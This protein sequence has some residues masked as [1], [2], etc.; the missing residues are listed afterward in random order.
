MV[1]PSD[2]HEKYGWG[3]VRL[4][5]LLAA[6]CSLPV[7]KTTAALLGAFP[8]QRVLT[9]LCFGAYGALVNSHVMRGAAL[10]G[11]SLSL[12]G[13]GVAT[14]LF[15]WDA[16]SDA[17]TPFLYIV[18]TAVGD[19]F[20]GKVDQWIWRLGCGLVA[21]GVV[22]AWA[23]GQFQLLEQWDT[24]APW[25]ALF[26]WM[27]SIQFVSEYGDNYLEHWAFFRHRYCFEVGTLALLMLHNPP[28]QQRVVVLADLVAILAYRGV[29]FI[30]VWLAG[31]HAAKWGPDA[32]KNA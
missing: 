5:L 18:K 23:L 2:R 21:L 17:L 30:I 13:L 32:E 25:A 28:T 16:K 4:L 6:V 19:F 10:G 12:L 3:T 31:S 8:P 15:L 22:S 11:V 7:P 1:V 20:A 9:Y 29:N 24:A 26:V 14:A 27:T